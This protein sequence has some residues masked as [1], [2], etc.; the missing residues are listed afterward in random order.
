MKLLDPSIFQLATM[1]PSPSSLST[2]LQFVL[3][4]CANS[5]TSPPGGL[6]QIDVCFQYFIE[7][8]DLSHR[9]RDMVYLSQFFHAAW[10]TVHITMLGEYKAPTP[11]DMDILKQVHNVLRH[12]GLQHTLYKVDDSTLTESEFWQLL[13]DYSIK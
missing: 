2:Q 8:A 13:S 10:N 9:E 5:N 3:D 11:Y 7:Q 4:T 6:S 12:W 1:Q